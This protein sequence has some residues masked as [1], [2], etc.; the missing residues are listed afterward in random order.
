MG[1]GHEVRQEERAH[2]M[3]ELEGLVGVRSLAGPYFTSNR[4]IGGFLKQKGEIYH[5][6]LRQDIGSPVRK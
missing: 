5:R 6:Q 2:N 1:E 4:W 3:D